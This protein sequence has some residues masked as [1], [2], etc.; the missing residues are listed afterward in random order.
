MTKV[1]MEAYFSHKSYRYR[2][3]LV[4]TML[5]G[6][7]GSAI[8]QVSVF[9]PPPSFRS[10][11][12]GICPPLDGY[13]KS[14]AITQEVYDLAKTVTDSVSPHEV[15]IEC[16]R[17]LL[18]QSE[19]LPFEMDRWATFVLI[20]SA[21]FLNLR[22]EFITTVQEWLTAYPDQ[23]RHLSEEWTRD[24]PDEVDANIMLRLEVA[25]KLETV[26][27]DSLNWPFAERLKMYDEI[28]AP[29]TDGSRSLLSPEVLYT[30][31]QYTRGLESLL[32]GYRMSGITAIEREFADAPKQYSEAMKSYELEEAKV[33]QWVGQK[34]LSMAEQLAG[35]LNEGLRVAPEDLMSA[36]KL[37]M[38]DLIRLNK[39]VGS[40]LAQAHK[41]IED[42]RERLAEEAGSTQ[43]A[44]DSIVDNILL[45]EAQGLSTTEEQDIV[46]WVRVPQYGERM[47]EAFAAKYGS[48]A[49]PFLLDLLDQEPLIV[50]RG[51]VYDC[52]GKIGDAR[53]VGPIIDF[54]ESKPLPN[55]FE[56]EDYYTYRSA[57]LSLGFIGTEECLEHIRAY[58]T[59]QYW[60]ERG[61]LPSQGK[62]A[63]EFAPGRAIPVS[64]LTAYA[65]SLDPNALSDL[66]TGKNIPEVLHTSIPGIL[67]L[68]DSLQT[69]LSRENGP[70][71]EHEANP[72]PSVDGDN[73]SARSI[74]EASSAVGLRLPPWKEALRICQDRVEA[75]KALT[76]IQASRID[77]FSLRGSSASTAE[78]YEL[79]L[80][81]ANDSTMPLNHR[82]CYLLIR[83]SFEQALGKM[84]EALETLKYA[85]SRYP[86]SDTVAMLIDAEIL[87]Y[88]RASGVEPAVAAIYK[89]KASK[90]NLLIVTW[91]E[92]V[93]WNERFFESYS[94]F[95][96]R[97]IQQRL[98][99]VDSCTSHFTDSSR[100]QSRELATTHLALAEDALSQLVNVQDVKSI[101]VDE[102]E[103]L[104]NLLNLVRKR[105]EREFSKG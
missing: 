54:V 10:Y 39:L 33:K 1:H 47:A 27:N 14:G 87:S 90:K 7:C 76:P 60:A 86:T 68:V 42:G 74:S 93:A 59:D 66:Q 36:S 45:S 102:R 104:Y 84:P 95:N 3:A 25:R 96:P 31:F 79:L 63:N 58:M 53:A 99:F 5:A 98:E 69:R 75:E 70:L 11:L 83:S 72:A 71:P 77:E 100:W 51:H 50:C 105:V 26:S 61:D 18:N 62:F 19:K 32:A 52:L 57:I 16:C 15:K 29:I 92:E 30:Q 49:V 24:H 64:A 46:E 28:L 82:T 43:A 67:K 73:A 97:V 91:E 2:F 8:C 80:P 35:A 13:L 94:P 6:L 41:N 20:D 65:L 38:D 12:V 40:Q 9:A 85:R 21:A 4:A 17:S 34:Q 78:L 89:D 37:G 101:D 103:R 23:Q 81:I 48:R 44:T 56:L 22:D 55:P 88:L